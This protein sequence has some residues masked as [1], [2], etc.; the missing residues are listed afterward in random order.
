MENWA[1]DCLQ[2]LSTSVLIFQGDSYCD[3]S[4][5]GIENMVARALV[6]VNVCYVSVKYQVDRIR[7][8]GV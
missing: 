1:E 6:K 5:R 4:G 8:N 7:N 2:I 3:T